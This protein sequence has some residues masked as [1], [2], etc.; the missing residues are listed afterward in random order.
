MNAKHPTVFEEL[1]QI[2][3]LVDLQREPQI[4]VEHLPFTVR[5]VR[6]EADLEKAVRV[7]YEAYARHKP[8]FARGLCEPE[9]DDTK[10]NTVIMLAESKLD[11]SALGTVRVQI[12]HDRPLNMERSIELPHWLQGKVLS[13]ARRLAVV[14]GGTGGLVKTVLFKALFLYWEQEEVDW[15]VVAARTPLDRMYE[16][17]DFKDALA[18][19]T[20]VPT[21]VE[22]NLPHRVLAFEISSAYARWSALQHPLLKF[23]INTVHP[24]I[25]V[26]RPSRHSNL[27]APAPV[28]GTMHEFERRIHSPLIPP[29]A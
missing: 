16:G 10:P 15:A 6:T 13:D 8:D 11:G 27:S 4:P 9:D 29:A 12:N 20:F 14:R 21:P 18:G 22:N 7:R 28:P 1:K 3:A 26:A 5:L 19:D 17:L 23:V 24:D 2:D 25:Q